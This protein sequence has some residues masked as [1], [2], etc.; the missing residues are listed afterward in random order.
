MIKYFI[1][2]I[3]CFITFASLQGSIQEVSS[4]KEAIS[5]AD[6]K[7]LVLVNLSDTLYEPTITMGEHAWRSFFTKRV[8]ALIKDT[9]RANQIANKVKHDIV[10][11]IPKRAIEKDTPLV[12]QG[13]Q[14]KYIPIFGI[15]TKAP[16]TPYASDFSEITHSHLL[17]LGI[18]FENTLRYVPLDL[19]AVQDSAYQ[20]LNGIIYTVK[21]PEGLA[22]LAFLKK[23][24]FVPERVIVVNDSLRALNDTAKTLELQGVAFEGYRYNKRDAKKKAFDPVLGVIQFFAFYETGKLLSDEEALKI[25]KAD[26]K[27]D[28]FA[29]L[30]F[31]ILNHF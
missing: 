11:Q 31:Y 17:S 25:K 18:E 24:P 13:L 10:T 4:F 7:S 9:E 1:C 2:L 14:K 29:K 5:K 27:A 16:Q 22:T 26:P 30:D 15:T 3:S 12:I 6:G 8:Q 19:K 21:Q 20:F 28:L 23:L